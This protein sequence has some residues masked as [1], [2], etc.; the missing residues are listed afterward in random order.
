MKMF[1][2]VEVQ[3]KY[4]ELL[5][6]YNTLSLNYDSLVEATKSKAFKTIMKNLETDERVEYYKNENK[7]LR[8]KIK[9][10]KQSLK[11]KEGKNK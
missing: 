1:S 9:E 6:Q 5:L 11:E 2:K 7:K 3:Q 10:L 8:K 4:N